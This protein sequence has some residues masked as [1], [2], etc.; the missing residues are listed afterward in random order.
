M[1][2]AKVRAKEQL[3]ALK[4]LFPSY[5]GRTVVLTEG[6]AAYISDYWDE[7]CRAYP[8]LFYP[9]DPSVDKAWYGHWER[10][11]T[12]QPM[13]YSGMC[14]GSLKLEPGI[15]LAEHVYSGDKQY[16][17]VTLHPTEDRSRWI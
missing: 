1:F 14:T 16:L 4:R 17:R 5:K 7:G 15:G 13:P 10:L 11:F 2:Y 12:P 6:E 9:P 8:K 3:P